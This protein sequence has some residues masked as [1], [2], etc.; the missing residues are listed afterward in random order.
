MRENTRKAFDR[1]VREHTAKANGRLLSSIEIKVCHQNGQSSSTMCYVLRTCFSNEQVT[2]TG[3]RARKK[4]LQVTGHHYG[5]LLFYVTYSFGTLNHALYGSANHFMDYLGRSLG[6]DIAGWSSIMVDSIAEW[7]SLN[8]MR[9]NKQ[10]YLLIF[11][12]WIKK[13]TSSS[14]RIGENNYC[15]IKKMT[16]SCM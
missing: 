12:G 15:W 13:S 4:I 8:R 1:Y 14:T 3:E 2:G 6:V 11:S 7:E 16:A 10:T 5:P 9:V